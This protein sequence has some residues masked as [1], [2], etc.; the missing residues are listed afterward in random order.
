MENKII[1]AHFE[2]YLNHTAANAPSKADLNCLEKITA[3]NERY[4]NHISPKTLQSSLLPM[5]IGKTKQKKNYRAKRA[6]L[7]PHLPKK[8]IPE[9]SPAQ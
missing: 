6:L 5:S 8:Y 9:R 3:Q 2:R 4:L 1:N 7:E